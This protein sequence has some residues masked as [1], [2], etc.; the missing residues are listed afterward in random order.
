MNCAKL[1]APMVPA[2]SATTCRSRPAVWVALALLAMP[3]LAG[4]SQESSSSKSPSGSDPVVARV[5]GAEVRQSDLFIAMDDL[6]DDLKQVSPDVMRDHLITYVA[7]ILLVARAAEQKNL[8]NSDSFKQRIAFLRAKLLM[9]LLLQEHAKSAATEEAMQQ[10]YN[11][12]IKPMGATEEVRARHILFRA[13]PKDEKAMAEAEAKA[14]AA[15]ERIKKGEDFATVASELTE[16]PT[17][18]K[19]GGD[20]GYFTK[21]QMVP[22]F[23]NIEFQMHAGLVSNPIR[24]PFGWHIIKLE[25]R[26]K[27]PVPE[28]EKV[29]GQIE[30]FVIRRA[31]TELVAQLRE[32]AKI[33]RLDGKGNVIPAPPAEKK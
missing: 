25:D 29:R 2:S 33:E 26:R 8:Q 24:T 12:Q 1:P 9:G 27:R 3:L 11:E 4:C 31:Q 32:K 16:D 5:N 30:A 17:G 18:T 6:G 10:V 14:R 21:D 28:Y 22:E 20:L 19:D 13:E 15:L 7:D 23:A